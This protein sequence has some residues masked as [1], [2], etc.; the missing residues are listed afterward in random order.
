VTG[1]AGLSIDMTGLANQ[2]SVNTTGTTGTVVATIDA[3]KATYTGGAG[4][5]SVTLSSATVSKAINTEAGNDTVTLAAGT[6]SLTANVSG[7]ENTDTLVM[8]AADAATA[9]QNSLFAAKI[10]GFEQLSLGQET[11]SE[12]VNLANLDGINYVISAGGAASNYLLY[13]VYTSTVMSNFNTMPSGVSVTLF[14][15]TLT[16]SAQLSATDVVSALAGN[17]VAGATI[18]GTL[19]NGVTLTA[20]NGNTTLTVAGATVTSA[21]YGNSGSV[22]LTGMANGGTLELTDTADTTTVTMADATGTGDIFNIVTKVDGSNLNFGTVAVAGVETLNITAT[23]ITPVNTV[24]GAAT[25]SEAT[26]T[27]TNTALKSA[28]ISGNADLNLTAAS[29]ALTSVDAS[30]L[31]GV[32]TF[33]SA[34]N[35]AVVTGGSAADTSRIDSG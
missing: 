10:D 17:S 23:D 6:T 14:G 19:P 21:V 9:S 20:G 1:T 33:S 32:L 35:N 5:D 28:V 12:S 2:T 30:A 31:T 7:G 29:T 26:L 34:A 16:S 11:G 27:V 25:I 22:T 3:S 15:W 8:A 18:T 13:S 24:T 4:V